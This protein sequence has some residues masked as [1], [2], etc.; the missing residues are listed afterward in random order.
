MSEQTKRIQRVRRTISKEQPPQAPGPPAQLTVNASDIVALAQNVGKL[1]GEV[2]G[3]K[4]RM[5][6]L[7]TAVK[8]NEAATGELKQEVTA[9][10]GTVADLAKDKTTPPQSGASGGRKEA[11]FEGWAKTMEALKTYTPWL[12]GLGVL[13]AGV[14]GALLSKKGSASA[15]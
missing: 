10:S 14:I 7:E 9:L 11:G 12:Y 3:M 4:D 2:R 6:K 5:D 15:P 8:S 13:L 1:A